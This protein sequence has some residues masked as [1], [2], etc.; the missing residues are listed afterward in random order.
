MELNWN[1]NLFKRK[2][3]KLNKK[4]RVKLQKKNKTGKKDLKL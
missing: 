2:K 3:L 4:K 1:H